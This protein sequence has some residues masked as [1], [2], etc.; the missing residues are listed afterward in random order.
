MGIL[1]KSKKKSSKSKRKQ[2]TLR[3]NFFFVLITLIIFIIIFI[4]ITSIIPKKNS[5]RSNPITTPYFQTVAKSG[6]PAPAINSAYLN[7]K[8]FS[9]LELK[10]KMIILNFWVSTCPYCREEM[11]W[12]EKIHK[13]NNGSIAI[14]GI[15]T[16]E[17]STKA[18][19]FIDYLNITYPIIIDSDASI[20]RSYGIVYKPSTVLIS[21]KGN[22]I[23]RIPG[24]LSRNL[25]SAETGKYLQDISKKEFSE[26]NLSGSALDLDKTVRLCEK[27]C[28]RYLYMPKFVDANSAK[29]FLSDDDEVIG[30]NLGNSQKAYPV[31]IMNWHE[32]VNDEIGGNP[33]LVTYSPFGWAAKA[34]ERKV[35]GEDTVFGSSGIIYEN[36]PLLY[37][38][39]TNSL[40]VQ[41]Q[42]ISASGILINKTLKQI[43][44]DV[45]TFGEWR[46]SHPN[47][48]V[49]SEDTKYFLDYGIYPYGNYRDSAKILFPTSFKFN[50][51][52]NPKLLVQSI[53]MGAECKSYSEELLKKSGI[54]S[55][56]IGGVFLKI[57]YNSS[58]GAFT[59]Y[60][61]PNGSEII[62]TRSFWFA[63]KS[64]NSNSELEK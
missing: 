4:L 21:P 8:P 20:Q 41:L 7:G 23:K 64:L 57:A 42:G 29:S 38:A 24:Q 47:G 32:V 37:D 10:G 53:C 17:K 31:K 1:S 16:G 59:A 39:K 50:A 55:D 26:F 19:F 22:I 58:S 28:L 5:D 30:I 2:L 35:S 33:I 62:L 3:D 36:N 11:P 25:L 34:Y 63:W 49:M 18:Q 14:I 54:K 46:M 43:R 6:E 48:T 61:G 40:W 52:S 15:N 13:E 60:G 12:L 9:L 51:G 44:N 27:D 56:L 45:T